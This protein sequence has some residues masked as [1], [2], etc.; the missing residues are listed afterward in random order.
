MF[1]SC[2]MKQVTV[3]KKERHAQNKLSLFSEPVLGKWNKVMLGLMCL[4][5]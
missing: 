3:T 1:V 2:E 5:N 4:H